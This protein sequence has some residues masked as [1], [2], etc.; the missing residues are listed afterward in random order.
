MIPK[1]MDVSFKSQ[2]SADNFIEDV[3][4]IKEFYEV[5]VVDRT[6][7]A[8]PYSNMQSVLASIKQIFIYM[9]VG[10][11]PFVKNGFIIRL[12]MDV[13]VP[14]NPLLQ[15]PFNNLDVLCNGFIMT[16][17]GGKQFSRNTGTIIDH[18]SDYERAVVIPQII[19]DMFEF[20]TYICMTTETRNRFI[21]VV[22]LKRINKLLAKKDMNWTM[23]NLPF[24]K[25]IYTQKDD[26]KHDCPICLD[27]IDNNQVVAYT[28][29]VKENDGEEI[30]TGKLHYKCMMQYLHCQTQTARNWNAT[31]KEN[32]FTFKCPFRNKISFTR[33]KLD[34]QFAYK[35]DL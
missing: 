17:E 12:S 4:N 19:K 6:Y 9:R 33:C 32:I 23:L 18:Y 34:I 21:N 7:H 20:K 26:E 35:T 27:A 13:V 24:R 11:I 16:S 29:S 8:G 1:D 30:P 25:E 31:A 15:P 3:K 2:E 10:H 14:N 28:S 5:C 22:S